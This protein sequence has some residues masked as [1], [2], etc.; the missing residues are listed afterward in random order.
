MVLLSWLV[1][2][3]LFTI[4]SKLACTV[5]FGEEV[6]YSRQLIKATC[7]GKEEEI[8]ITLQKLRSIG[9]RKLAV[10]TCHN[11]FLPVLPN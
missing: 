10:P 4:L 2:I 11:R 7:E 1:P 9:V 8:L 6:E 5:S 3:L